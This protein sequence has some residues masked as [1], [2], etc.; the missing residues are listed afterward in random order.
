VEGFADDVST[1]FGAPFV[2]VWLV[3]PVAVLSLLS[4]PYDAVIKSVPTGKTEVVMI[5]EFPLIVPD[6]RVTPP[7]VIVILPVVPVGTAAVIVTGAP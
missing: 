7:L 4:P 5:T 3:V 6:P 1:T 2:T